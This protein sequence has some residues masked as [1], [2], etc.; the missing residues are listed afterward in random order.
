MKWTQ[1]PAPKP[2]QTRIVRRFLWLPLNLQ[3]E[4][5]WLERAEWVERFKRF[6]RYDDGVYGIWKPV[7]WN[8]YAEADKD[9]GAF[10]EGDA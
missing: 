8:D 10:D 7:R 2:G 5:R 4:T 9:S 6:F 1:P 3:G